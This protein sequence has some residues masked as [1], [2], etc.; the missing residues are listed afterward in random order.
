M[1][2]DKLDDPD[3]ELVRRAGG[4]DSAACAALVDRHL[5]R[6]LALAVRML[7]NRADAEDVAQETFL[8]VWQR[9]ASWRAGDAQFSTWL[10]RVALNLCHDRLRQ[11][12]PQVDVDIVDLAA[13]DESGEHESQRGAVAAAVAGAL[14]GLPERQREAIVLCYYQEL[15]N[16]EAAR[17]LDV[18]VEALE[19]LL[20]RARRTLRETLRSRAEDLIG[21]VP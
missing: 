11:R 5:N 19:S 14:M 2:I 15:G 9:A 7:G 10:Y 18:S 8:R 4:G 3:A 21:E 6:L 1:R 12:R 16:I 17:V 13:N 20:S